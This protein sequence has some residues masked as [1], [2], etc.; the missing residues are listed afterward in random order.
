MTYMPNCCY[1]NWLC[2]TGCRRLFADS[3]NTV[4]CVDQ[5]KAKIDALKQGIIPIYEPGLESLVK[6]G[7]SKQRLQFTTS[8]SEA[9]SKSEIV[10]LAVG[11]PASPSGEPDLRF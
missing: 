2:W 5:D 3:G 1:W 11:T 6:Q 4:I 7:V 8:T 9:V 10:F